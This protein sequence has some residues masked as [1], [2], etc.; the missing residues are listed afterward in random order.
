MGTWSLRLC[1][2]SELMRGSPEIRALNF[3]PTPGSHAAQPHICANRSQ[4][5]GAGMW[6]LDHVDT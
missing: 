5:A 3:T 4:V 1:V 6:T 2:G